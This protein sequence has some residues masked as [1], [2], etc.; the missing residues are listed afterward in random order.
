MPSFELPY[1]DRILEHMKAAPSSDLARAFERNVHWGYFAAPDAADGSV[2]GY[3][4]AAEALTTRMCDAAE[5]GDNMAILDVGCGFGGTI[6]HLND[7][8]AHCDLVGLNVDARQLERARR[9]VTAAR[10]NRVEFV[11][12]D[13]CELPFA[14]AHFDRVLAVECIFHFQS[15]RKFFREV[16][17]VLKPGGRLVLSDFVLNDERLADLGAWMNANAAPSS[18][19][20][21]EN[22]VPP[23]GGRYERL[24]RQSQLPRLSDEDITAQTLPTYPAMRHI[25]REAGLPD[26][27]ESTTYLE[28]LAVGGFVQYRILSFGKHTA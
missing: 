14:D 3:V 12:G 7:S 5:V 25:Y 6:H 21:G 18:P 8:V 19:Y 22:R 10:E 17:R 27:V 4:A 1:F 16:G 15:R 28:G 2:E 26:A 11:E 20:Y 24:G 23:T 13:A 9:I